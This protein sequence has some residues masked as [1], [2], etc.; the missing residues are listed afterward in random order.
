MSP[1][2]QCFINRHRS[3]VERYEERIVVRRLLDAEDAKSMLLSRLPGHLGW[4]AAE[5]LESLQY[6]PL[7]IAQAASYISEEG[8]GQ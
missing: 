1:W 4:T 7:A 8:V 2:C 5:G 6:L 3:A